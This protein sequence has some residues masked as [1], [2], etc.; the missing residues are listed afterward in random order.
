[1]FVRMGKTVPLLI[2]SDAVSAPTGLARITRDLTTRIYAHMSDLFDVATAGY[3][4]CGSTKFPWMQ[5]H[6]EGMTSDW[7]LPSLPEICADHFKGRQGIIWFIWDL[8]R[9]GWFARPDNFRDPLRPFPELQRWLHTLNA[10]KW[11]YTP[12]DAESPGGRLSYPLAQAALGFNRLFCYGRWAAENIINGIGP[13]HAAG[14]GLTALPHGID[15][16]IFTEMPRSAARKMFFNRTGAQPLFKEADPIQHDELLIGIVAT[17]QPR[18]DWALGIEVAAKLKEKRP[19]RLWIHTDSLEKYWS[20]PTLL[21][22]FGF[23]NPNLQAGDPDRTIVSLGYMTDERMAEAYSAC[24]VTLGI[25]SGEGFGY[26]IFESIFCGTPCI[27][28]NYGGAPEYMGGDTLLV[29]PVGYRYESAYGLKRPVFNAD[30]WAAKV[31]M[32]A[33]KRINHPE[34]LDWEKLWP[35]WETALRKAVEE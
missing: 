1:M 18:K 13:E 19:V 28:G 21:V 6:L 30:D 7:V 12:I 22:D 32:A 24:D 2:V 11:L 10:Q 5:Y 26:P 16:D 3:G 27:H 31:E 25:G 15:S 35:H 9:L 33:G 23:I 34:E 14:R 17:N 8:G 29:E 4:A 20:I